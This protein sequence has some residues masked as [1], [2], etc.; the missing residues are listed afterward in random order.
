MDGNGIEILILVGLFIIYGKLTEIHKLMGKTQNAT[1][2]ENENKRIENKRIR[3]KDKNK[4]NIHIRKDK[5]KDKGKDKDVD[6]SY[7]DSY[8]YESDIYSSI[9]NSSN[10]SNTSNTSYESNTSD[11]SYSDNNLRKD[12]GS[13]EIPN[14]AKKIS[15][16]NNLDIARKKSEQSNPKIFTSRVKK[17]EKSA[18]EQFKR[19]GSNKS[20]IRGT[21]SGLGA[22]KLQNSPKKSQMSVYVDMLK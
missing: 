20:A 9:D 14:I 10:T 5:D 2:Y 11:K 8:T 18:P 15:G 12:R 6:Y 7:I 3:E 1:I 17:F 22:L 4:N 19:A 16:L 13:G 21:M